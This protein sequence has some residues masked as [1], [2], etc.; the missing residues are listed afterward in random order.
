[1]RR[2]RCIGR[3][4]GGLNFKLHA[5]CGGQGRPVVMML[6][7]GQM[8]DHKG[9]TLMLHALPPTAELLGG[10]YDS[11]GFREGLGS[12]RIKACSLSTS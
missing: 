12:R 11:D 4:K 9:A 5:V 2:S 6:T 10:G 7:E 3:T 1:M 8:N